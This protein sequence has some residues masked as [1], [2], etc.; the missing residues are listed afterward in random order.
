MVDYS[1]ALNQLNFYLEL[2]GNGKAVVS[3][4]NWQ[5]LIYVALTFIFIVQLGQVAAVSVDE[6]LDVFQC[7]L[8]C[9]LILFY[10]SI[11]VW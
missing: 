9:L 6:E 3:K 1:N 11:K 10:F 5:L 8:L 2:S 7:L 4:K